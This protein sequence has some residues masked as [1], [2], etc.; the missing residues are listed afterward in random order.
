MQIQIIVK[1]LLTRLRHAYQEAVKETQYVYSINEIMLAECVEQ[2]KMRFHLI[3]TGKVSHPVSLLDIYENEAML[4]KFIPSDIKI[5]ATA[6]TLLR[7]PP[8]RYHLAAIKY[9][10]DKT[11]Y[12]VLKQIH[13]EKI[14]YIPLNKVNQDLAILKK[15]DKKSVFRLGFLQG[16]NVGQKN[17]SEK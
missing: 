15:V 6:V 13:S 17:S 1:R 3:G 12:A 16:L 7:N 5:I 4:S 10:A 14:T 11:S 2:A 8:D 9:H